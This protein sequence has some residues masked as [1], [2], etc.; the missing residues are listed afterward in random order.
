MRGLRDGRRE[1]RGVERERRRGHGT[2]LSRFLFFVLQTRISSIEHRNRTDLIDN[3][4]P[5]YY[6]YG[7]LDGSDRRPTTHSSEGIRGPQDPDGTRSVQGF[8]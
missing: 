8:A 6:Y 2:S 4:I 1:A 5:A 3:L 7:N